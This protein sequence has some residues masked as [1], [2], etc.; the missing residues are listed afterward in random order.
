MSAFVFQKRLQKY[1]LNFIKQIVCDIFS[2]KILT[3][4]LSCL[5]LDDCDLLLCC[6]K[7]WTPNRAAV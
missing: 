3:Q 2:N 5:F 1:G 4:M 6:E 7:V